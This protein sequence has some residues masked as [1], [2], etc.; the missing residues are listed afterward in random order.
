MNHPALSWQSKANICV[1]KFIIHLFLVSVELAHIQDFKSQT[2]FSKG[3]GFILSHG[4]CSGDMCWGS[5]DMY[6][7]P[8]LWSNISIL[9]F[10]GVKRFHPGLFMIHISERFLVLQLTGR[11]WRTRNAST[12]V[13]HICASF[14]SVTHKTISYS[15]NITVGAGICPNSQWG[16]GRNPGCI[17][18]P[19]LVTKLSQDPLTCTYI[20]LICRCVECERKLVEPHTSGE[21]IKSESWLC[22]LGSILSQPIILYFL[23][24]HNQTDSW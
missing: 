16:R 21:P 22:P 10:W 12:S 8:W 9:Q 13:L 18:G 3:Q 19:E 24:S 6:F 1:S 15:H 11:S 2:Y 23:C 5:T 14:I 17:P 20:N 4:D 7:H